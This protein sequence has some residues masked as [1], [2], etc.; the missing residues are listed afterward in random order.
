[1]SSITVNVT[2]NSPSNAPETPTVIATPK[3]TDE[4]IRAEARRRLEV[5]NAEQQAVARLAAE[6]EK[7]KSEA[8]ELSVLEEQI[9]QRVK[10]EQVRMMAQ[11]A[12]LEAEAKKAAQSREDAIA[13]EIL[14]LKS[15]TEVEV[16]KDTVSELT[17]QI[18]SLKA[19]HNVSCRQ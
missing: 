11:R 9:R 12:V 5:A 15:R 13:A 16:L 19:S 18:A 8:I 6:Q 2:T 7:K 14:R 17:A 3:T 1:M 4:A 10:E